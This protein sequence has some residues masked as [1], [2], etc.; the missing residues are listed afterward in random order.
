MKRRS[1]FVA[2]IAVLS[3]AGEFA[4]GSGLAGDAWTRAFGDSTASTVVLGV[5][6]VVVVACLMIFRQRAAQ[7]PV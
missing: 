1:C 3:I 7:P 6:G 2:C 4:G 5:L